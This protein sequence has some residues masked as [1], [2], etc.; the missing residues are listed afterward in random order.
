MCN[1]PDMQRDGLELPQKFGKIITADHKVSSDEHESRM[2]HR[3]A[4]VLSR[5]SCRNGVRVI[6]KRKRFSDR[7]KVPQG[8][9]LPSVKPGGTYTD[10]APDFLRACENLVRNHDTSTPHRS[11]TTGTAERA[12]RR[13]R[14]GIVFICIG[15]HWSHRV[16]VE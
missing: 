11:E 8:F 3:Y 15:T 10:N 4:L 9:V 13:L 16:M 6:Q 12:V 7:T 5:I 1:T 14:E 2:Q